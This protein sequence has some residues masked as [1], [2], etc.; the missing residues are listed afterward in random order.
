[1]AGAFG[2]GGSSSAF[3]A[4]TGDVFTVVTV[5]LAA[6]FL[7]WFVVGNYSFIPGGPVVGA[8]PAAA[9][10]LP[11]PA[12]SDQSAVDDSGDSASTE[13]GEPAD[14]AAESQAGVNNDEPSAETSTP[15]D[16]A[17]EEQP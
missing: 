16:D 2:G 8:A 9:A 15:T 12:A 17:G 13:I 5:V 10:P 6:V 1:M 14:S 11:L 3:G 4:K 7:V